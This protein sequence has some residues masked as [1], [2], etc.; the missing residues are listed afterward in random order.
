MYCFVDVYMPECSC[1][2]V[3]PLLVEFTLFIYLFILYLSFL[4]RQDYFTHFETSQS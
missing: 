4:A 2:T 1:E 3:K